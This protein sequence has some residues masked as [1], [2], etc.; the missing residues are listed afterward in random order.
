M[1][2]QKLYDVVFEGHPLP[3]F[4][5]DQAI[6]GLARL[7][8]R[9][10]DDIVRFFNNTPS[11][12]K[13]RV[14]EQTAQKYCQVLKD[15]G[16]ACHIA[17]AVSDSPAAE[18][19]GSTPPS[20]LT[21]ESSSSGSRATDLQGAEKTP[22]EPDA[23]MT[24]EETAVADNDGDDRW[25]AYWK[26]AVILSLLTIIPAFLTAKDQ[27][28]YLAGLLMAVLLF[29]SF[30]CTRLVMKITGNDTFL[31]IVACIVSSGGVAAVY[32]FYGLVM[33]ISRL[34]RI[35]QFF[36]IYLMVSIIAVTA[37]N[38]VHLSQTLSP[39]QSASHEQID[40]DAEQLFH[41]LD[42]AIRSY[43]LE[44]GM[45]PEPMTKEVFK[46]IL[47]RSVPRTIANGLLE[48]LDDGRLKLAGDLAEYRIGIY[49]NDQWTIL[50]EKGGIHTRDA[51]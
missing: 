38:F 36:L 6:E 40:A 51:F 23:R 44:F 30:P 12:L 21:A 11:V 14:P 37:G 10:P 4:S 18:P 24:S 22:S 34:L 41:Q 9:Q 31:T 45:T 35:T 13:R 17:L 15:A 50:D 7:S 27:S 16:L 8:K 28:P 19:I 2:V 3:G 33:G 46:K 1:S 20:E 32:M 47:D 48:K 25:E 39:A 26:G 5:R 29:I 43:I 49:E 42:P